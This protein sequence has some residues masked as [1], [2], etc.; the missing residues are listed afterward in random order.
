MKLMKP[1]FRWYFLA[2]DLI[3]VI[4]IFSIW[5]NWAE[6][7]FAFEI[8]FVYLALCFTVFF[9]LFINPKHSSLFG[10]W[11]MSSLFYFIL[12]YVCEV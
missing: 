1:C 7:Q 8:L 3:Q 12:F 10:T 6:Y 11:W 5:L 2:T 9:V 4:N